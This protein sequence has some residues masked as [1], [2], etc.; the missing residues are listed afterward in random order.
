MSFLLGFMG[1]LV[2]LM[3]VAISDPTHWIPRYYRPIRHSS[4]HRVCERW[5][6]EY[7]FKRPFYLLMLISGI[8]MSALFVISLLAEVPEEV[9]LLRLAMGVGVGAYAGWRI[10]RKQEIIFTPY[11]IIGLYPNPLLVVA[12]DGISGYAVQPGTQSIVL[13]SSQ[14]EPVEAWPVRDELERRNMELAMMPFV[15]RIDWD[16]LQPAKLPGKSKQGIILAALALALGTLPLVMQAVLRAVSASSPELLLTITITLGVLVPV[17]I[18]DWAI[19]FRLV[20][21]SGKGHVKLAELT[22]LCQGC[23]YRPVCW[24]S[25]LQQRVRWQPGR[26]AAVPSW[27]EFRAHYHHA[28]ELDEQVYNTCCQC[29]IAHLSEQDIYRVT[30]H[31]LPVRTRKSATV[32]YKGKE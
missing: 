17:A 11:G 26:G 15:K 5:R 14:G 28:P 7:T 21:Y 3:L 1:L 22:M 12:W 20:Y 18:L 13:V 6:T 16:G 19:R 27:Q 24:E 31:D 9:L 2:G 4:V 32:N 30:L 23:Y 29:L 25:G 8:L 10:L